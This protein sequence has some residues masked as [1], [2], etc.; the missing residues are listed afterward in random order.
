MLS[1][2]ISMTVI[3]PSAF[4]SFSTVVLENLKPPGKA[5]I[6]AAGPWHNLVF[7]VTLLS[8]AKVANVVHNMTGLDSLFSGLIWK[9]VRDWGRVVVD[10]DEVIGFGLLLINLNNFLF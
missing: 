5:R 1:A 10:V 2:G 8:A 4:V 9:D 6:I 3:M 7:W